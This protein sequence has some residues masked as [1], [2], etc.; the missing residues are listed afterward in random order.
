[1]PLRGFS[2]KVSDILLNNYELCHCDGGY[3]SQA[4]EKFSHIC[5]GAN[6]DH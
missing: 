6:R 5:G 2:E 4:Q 3:K 1:M